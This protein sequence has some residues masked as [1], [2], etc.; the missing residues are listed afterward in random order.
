M[1]RLKTFLIYVLI[2]VAFFEFSKLLENGL[3]WQMYYEITG[4]VDNRLEYNRENL[5]LKVDVI[6]ARATRVNGYIDITVTNTSNTKI[7]EAYIK[8]KLYTKSNVY[9]TQK[10]M[11][12]N[13]LKPGESKKYKLR[14]KG[15]YIKRFVITLEKDYPDKDYI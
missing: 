5:E 6:D 7:D 9:A 3:I 2:I 4:N 11:E 10:Y 15:S 1:E 12:I 14:F 8:V 13:D